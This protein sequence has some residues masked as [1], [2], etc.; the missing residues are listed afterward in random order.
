[1]AQAT[2]AAGGHASHLKTAGFR[3]IAIG[4][5]NA[6][7]ATWRC[8]CGCLTVIEVVRALGNIQAF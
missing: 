1:M 2:V 3:D 5:A 4:K 6:D 7:L 8:L